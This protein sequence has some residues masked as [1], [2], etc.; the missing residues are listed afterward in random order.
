MEIGDTLRLSDLAMEGVAFLDD[1]EETVIATVAAPRVEGG[2]EE[3][4]EEEAAEGRGARGAAEEP[5]AE[6]P[7]PRASPTPRSRAPP[8]ACFAAASGAHLHA[9]DLLVVGLGNPGPSHGVDRHNVGW[10]VVDELARRH[11]GSFR[12]KFSGRLADSG[13]TTCGSRC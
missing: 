7:R 10:M 2:A 13:S 11:G 9:L 1:P 5:V 3:P 8:C 6:R 4:T 12:S